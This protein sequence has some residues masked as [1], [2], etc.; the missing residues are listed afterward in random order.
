[1]QCVDILSGIRI[2]G[3]YIFN[4]YMYINVGVNIYI[5]DNFKDY[6]CIHMYI[7]THWLPYFLP[8]IYNL[9]HSFAE[10]ISLEREWMCLILFSNISIP[11]LFSSTFFKNLMFNK[12][13]YYILILYGWEWK[14]ISKFVTKLICFLNFNTQPAPAPS[15][16]FIR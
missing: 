6:T 8:P 2:Y 15:L 9:T 3:L 1:M 5:Y 13:S 4:T 7:Q 11:I 12:I 14:T 16:Y 10:Y